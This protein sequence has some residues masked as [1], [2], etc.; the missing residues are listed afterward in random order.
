MWVILTDSLRRT[1]RSF[2]VR[3]V[4][5]LLNDATYVL[6]EALTRFPKIHD[7]QHE[8]RYNPSLTA[9]ERE[10]KEE[11]LQSAEGQAQSYM[12]LANETVS[13]MKLF[14]N[15]LSEAFTMPEIVQRLAGMLDYN[16]DTL[17][18][19]KSTS[20]K[21]ENPGKYSFNPRSLLA[22]IVDI[23]LNLGAIP[24]F[25]EA[26]ASDGRSY[27]AA[28]FDKSSVILRDKG[29]VAQ[30][31]LAAWNTL[32]ARF[33]VAKEALDQAE[34]DLGDIPAEYEDPIMGDLMKD[35]VVLPSKHVVDRSTIS[36]HLLSDPQD[37][38]TRQPMT[39]DDVV[40]ADELRQEIERWKKE[41]MAAAK[42]KIA[43][44][45]DTMDTTDG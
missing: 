28:T 38:F 10:K 14:T 18:G 29:L 17:V 26:V 4:N 24:S 44:A 42:A 25:V 45:A 8:L 23:Y 5:L 12:Q 35:P 9:Q 11:E 15:A 36:Q 33:A 22:E 34:M 20:L 2:F 21:V 16:L 37:P 3:F 13:M 39:I 1:N 6:D 32:R 27:K 19:P 41:K 31:K 30:D 40:P 7:L 43:D